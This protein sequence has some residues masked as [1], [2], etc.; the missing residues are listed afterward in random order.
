MA[1]FIQNVKDM[2]TGKSNLDISPE[3]YRDMNEDLKIEQYDLE[4]KS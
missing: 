1:E 3:E 4:G 2:E